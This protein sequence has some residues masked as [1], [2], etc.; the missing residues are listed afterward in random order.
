MIELF[1]TGFKVVTIAGMILDS[2]LLIVIFRFSGRISQEEEMKELKEVE[3][4]GHQT[5][6]EDCNTEGGRALK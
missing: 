2:L 3:K 4:I 6:D 5:A 1:A